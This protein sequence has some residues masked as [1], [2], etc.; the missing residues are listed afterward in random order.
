MRGLGSAVLFAVL[1]YSGSACARGRD[2][3][4][5]DAPPS[6]AVAL[7]RALPLRFEP[8]R[9]QTDGR[10]A[11]VAHGRG[12][13][14]YL[15]Q[16]GALLALEREPPRRARSPAAASPVDAAAPRRAVAL[17]YE[18]AG[19]RAPPRIEGVDPLPGRSNYLLGADPK[20]WHTDV[21]QY[22]RVRYHDVQP[23]VDVVYYGSDGRLE[24]DIEV[25]PNADLAGVRLRIAG[26]EALALDRG[27]NLR[28]PPCWEMSS[29]AARSSS[30]SA[31]ACAT[32]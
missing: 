31:T 19:A 16:A 6:S 24:F 18:L 5:A 23:G 17:R 11:F 28:V 4:A 10:A 25:A 32:S 12:S 14:V 29:S 27:G 1:L 21:P 3:R 9:G 8:N 7:M 15:T 26:A 30:R 13:S 22:R 20:R 2:A